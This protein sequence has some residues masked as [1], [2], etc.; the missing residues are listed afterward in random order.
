MEPRTGGKMN[1]LIRTSCAVALG[2]Q[3][4]SGTQFVY[5]QQAETQQTQQQMVEPQQPAQIA[6][7]AS[8]PVTTEQQQPTQVVQAT[9]EITLEKVEITGSSIKRVEAETALPVEVLTRETIER[10]GVTNAEQ[11]MMD[12]TSTTGVGGLVT[13]QNAGQQTYGQSAVSLRGL[14]AQRTLVLVNG[15]RLANF[16]PSSPPSVD[17][18]AIPTSAIDRVEILQ[19]GASSVYGSDAV[20]GVINVILRKNYQGFEGSGYVGTP[21]HPGGGQIEKLGFVT[22]FGDYNED[23][24]NWL[25]SADAEHDNPLYGYSRSFANSSWD[26][27]IYDSSATPSG[28]VSGPWVIGVPY[29]LQPNISA[30]ASVGYGNPLQ[31]TNNCASG[32]PQQK[33][34]T[35]NAFQAAGIVTCRFNAAWFVPLVPDIDRVD[36]VSNFSFK[37]NASTKLYSELLYAHTRTVLQEQPSPYNPDFFTTDT[38]F[39]G[40]GFDPTLLILPSNPYYPSAWLKSVAGTVFGAPLGGLGPAALNGAT[41][42][43]VGQP[44]AVTYRAYDGGPRVHTDLADQFRLI[45]GING[46]A[47]AWEYDAA[48]MFNQSRVEEDTNDGYQLMLPLVKLL[49]GAQSGP[50][51]FDPWV[52]PQNPTLAAQIR[53]TNYDGMVA[54]SVYST[55]SADGKVTRSLAT[56]PGGSMELAVGADFVRESFDLESSGP[57]QLGD[58]S[59]YGNPILPFS[60]QRLDEAAYAEIDA[61]FVRMLEADLSVRFD[62]YEATGSATSPKISFRFQPV[63]QVVMRASAGKGFRAPSLVELYQPDFV[64]TTAIIPDPGNHNIP[65]QYPEEFGG[66]ANLKPEKSTQDSIGFVIEPNKHFSFSEDYFSIRVYDA[67]ENLSPGSVLLLALHGVSP[68]TSEVQRNPLTNTLLLVQTLNLNIGTESAAGWETNFR[69][70]SDDYSFGRI[71]TT[72]TG[73]YMSRF[74]VSQPDG[75]VQHSVAKTVDQFDN[76]LTATQNGGVVMRWRHNL[77]ALLE[78]HNW[79][80]SI[81][82]HYQAGYADATDN[83]GNPHNVGSFSTYDLEYAY[84]A[85]KNVRLQLGVKNILDTPPPVIAGTGVYFQGGYDPTYYDARARFVYASL[86]YKFK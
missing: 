75:T 76:A 77:E 51:A 67:I 62:H 3:M 44:I 12:I 69:W 37:L 35:S 59:G 17:I 71:T 84:T 73:T 41:P 66:N 9:P 15:R 61:P 22:G 1:K 2:V 32:G 81:I 65:G 11:L 28:N 23:R 78:E 56:L 45:A 60:H 26:Q 55:S 70:R 49:D 54:N 33:L 38:A 4:V 21:T 36:L 46:T 29:G 68:Y 6:Q 85:M 20:A 72:L 48:L 39:K 27:A 53:G 40:S 31:A 19:D 14:G 13:A 43:M 74:D 80:A 64:G 18:N 83:L 7:A 42:N 82:Q 25:I 10:L 50:N 34:D 58:I 86:T 8:E 47:G 79:S 57:A 30:I 24:F 5:A 16:A 52:Y 63:D